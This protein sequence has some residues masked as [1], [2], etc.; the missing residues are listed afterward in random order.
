MRAVRHGLGREDLP[1]I[2]V[3]GGATVLVLLAIQH[4]GTKLGA[5]ILLGLIA[6][7]ALVAGWL[8]APHIVV[9]VA[10]P[11]FAV[12]P[13]AKVF[14]SSSLGPVKDA[15]TLA[16]GVAVLIT[17][18]RRHRRPDSPH[19]DSLL[20]WLVLVFG[21]LYLVNLGGTIAGGGHG[22]AWEQGFRLVCEPLILLLAGLTL[23]NPRRSLDVAVASLIGTGVV[24]ALYGLYQQ[25]IGP[26]GLVGMGY[27][28]RSEV[29]TIGSHLRSFGSLDDPFTYAAFLFL[30]LSGVIFWMRRGALAFCC[31]TVI[32]FGIAV[33]FVRTAAVISVALVAIWLARK[34]RGV[35]ALIM[36]AASACAA[37][38]LLFAQAGASETHT[39]QAGP[40]TYITLNGRTTVWKTIF[41]N[42]AQ[43][44]FGVGVGQVGTAAQRASESIR[45]GR[46][47]DNQG[48]HQAVDSAYFA[49]VA[50]I[51]LLG[52]LVVLAL[53]TR[54]IILAH[55]GTRAA[56]GSSAGWLALALL[57]TLLIDAITRESFNGFPTAYIGLLIVGL[58]IARTS[59][60]T[61]RPFV[62]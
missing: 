61:I 39:V 46:A 49:T 50:D 47:S 3:G 62:D 18:A 43:L 54:L 9:G 57:S 53:F 36:L 8:L 40:N 32:A 41:R 22:I 5:G 60:P 55:A 10:I 58:A 33:S 2:A 51:G 29:R 19:V 13:A 45:G 56:V 1:A 34:G 30:S 23:S 52:L 42:P 6:F 12:L 11:L 37:L 17:V 59:Q 16:A 20:F 14:V 48:S 24:V 27:S 7:A 28:Y 35:L 44:P 21:G 15:V 25:Y 4:S 26:A 31:A 38:T